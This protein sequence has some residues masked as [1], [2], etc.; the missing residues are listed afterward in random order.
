MRSGS[1]SAGDRIQLGHAL[2]EVGDMD[3]ALVA[4]GDVARLY[5]LHLDA[6]RQY[7]LYLRRVGR[8]MDARNVLA[9]AL[10]L[11][12][13]AAG[14]AIEIADMQ[15]TD[16]ALLDRYFLLG[17]LGGSDAKTNDRPG[18]ISRF[19]A[20]WALGQ[21]RKSARIFDWPAAEHHYREVL[22]HAPDRAN[23]RVQLGHALLEQNRPA[24]ALACYRRAL[25]SSPRDPDLYLHVGHTLKQ[26]KRRNS[27]FDAYLTAWRLKPGLAA[28]FDEIRGLRPEIDDPLLLDREIGL[29]NG[30]AGG[31]D[32]AN[33]RRLVPPPRLSEGQISVFKY[34]AGSIVYKD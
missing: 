33:R 17:I 9:R 25:V 2:K 28:A 5:P 19:Q 23:A 11:D 22:R 3:A 15:A 30:E 1:A 8:E 29:T 26:L 7:G 4:Y 10:A 34:L 32:N 24:D 20:A 13:D 14:A 27:A 6:Q 18:L 21:A 16:A 12:P 31:P